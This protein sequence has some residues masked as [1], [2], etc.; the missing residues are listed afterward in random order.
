[1]RI[2]CVLLELGLLASAS[3]EITRQVRGS[4]LRH[5]DLSADPFLRAHEA[6]SVL[7]CQPSELV[8]VRLGELGVERL[9][10]LNDRMHMRWSTRLWLPYSKQERE[11][12]T[13]SPLN[14]I[15]SCV[16]Q[17]LPAPRDIA[18]PLGERV[19]VHL[20]AVPLT[21]SVRSQMSTLPLVVRELVAP[22][23]RD[24][25]EHHRDADVSKIDQHNHAPVAR[26]G[27]TADRTRPLLARVPVMPSRAAP[28]ARAGAKLSRAAHLPPEALASLIRQ[29]A[30][31]PSAGRRLSGHPHPTP[32]PQRDPVSPDR[33]QR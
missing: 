8:E 15:P 9:S 28:P 10:E 2:P 1:M 29:T 4:S 24:G 19:F 18:R 20:A 26:P 11:T 7:R 13:V 3:N 6:E 16:V 27:Q 14:R 25:G 31:V 30:R 23:G 12:A 21:V 22:G 32:A 5:H 17:A 33:S